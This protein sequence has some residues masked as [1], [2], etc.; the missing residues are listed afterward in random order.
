MDPEARYKSHNEAI[1][2]GWLAPNE[3]RREED[4]PDVDG[5]ETPY[6]Q[7]Q[8]YS[9]A[10]LARRDE[11]AMQPPAPTPPPAEQMEEQQ[12]SAFFRRSLETLKQELAA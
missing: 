8:N 3:A 5:G 6:M 12:R 9:L 2:G 4:M 11:M 7:Q 10:A 1:K